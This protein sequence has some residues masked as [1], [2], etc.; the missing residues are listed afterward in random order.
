[1]IKRVLESTA[2]YH[3]K[4]EKLL[5]LTIDTNNDL[6]RNVI[7]ASVNDGTILKIVLNTINYSKLIFQPILI[8]QIIIFN[9]LPVTHLKIRK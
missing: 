2:V 1:L 8:Q 4:G 5:S 3:S 6:L 9:N 7:Y